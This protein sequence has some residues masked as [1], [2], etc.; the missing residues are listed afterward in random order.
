MLEHHSNRLIAARQTQQAAALRQRFPGLSFGEAQRIA[1]GDYRP[2]WLE[3]GDLAVPAAPALSEAQ[4][5]Q[6]GQDSLLCI[7]D[8]IGEEFPGITDTPHAIAARR[9]CKLG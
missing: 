9:N 7:L 2:D 3:D 4:I 8:A 1:R 6:A 5:Q